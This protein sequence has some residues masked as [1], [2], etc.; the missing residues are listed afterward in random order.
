MN[1]KNGNESIIKI[2]KKL[3][4]EDA[5]II[6]EIL[7]PIFEAQQVDLSEVAK[8]LKNI[9]EYNEQHKEEVNII[10]LNTKEIQA[11]IIGDWDDFKQ[12]KPV[13]S[14]SK[15]ITDI[16]ESI[17]SAMDKNKVIS[18][19]ELIT[20]VKHQI[21]D[22]FNKKIPWYKNADGI[23]KVILSI[24]VIV[25]LLFTFNTN[26]NNFF[27]IPNKINQTIQSV[28]AP[29]IPVLPTISK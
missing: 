20:G 25:T 26:C 22:E 16:R 3:L 5:K 9:N 12:G 28:P 2:N 21:L 29:T 15:D 10:K 27:Q 8:Y 24:M 1:N 14:M 18:I 19:E 6:L 17:S 7:K 23:Y 13:K 11:V 4:S